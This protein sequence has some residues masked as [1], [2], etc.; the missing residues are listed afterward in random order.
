MAEHFSSLLLRILT[1]RTATAKAFVALPM[2]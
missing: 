2:A 1:A